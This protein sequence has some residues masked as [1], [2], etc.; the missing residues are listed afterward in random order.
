[1]FS[2][3]V[4][5]NRKEIEKY[6]HQ[7]RVSSIVLAITNKVDAE[8]TQILMNCLEHS[9]EV[10]P[11][12]VVYEQ[13]TGRVPVEHVGESWFVSMPVQHRTASAFY[14]FSKRVVDVFL[15]L[16]GI[17]LLTP[18]F[19][20]IALAIYIDSPGPTFYTQERV[21]KA[22]RRF[23][24]WKFRSMTNDAEKN[25][26]QWATKNDPRVTRVGKILRKTHLDEF[27]QFWNILK[28][29]MSAVGPR[30]ERPEWIE[31]L[32]KTIPFYRTRL[33][34]KPGM[35]GWGLVKQGYG[36]S[37]EDALVK[38]QYDL[39]Y[40]K[41]QS[42]FLDFVILLKTVLDTFSFGGR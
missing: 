20:L 18:I 14:R 28:G 32:E 38:L 42:I 4:L 41:H 8:L 27:P 12:A 13:L 39:Y 3:R 11:M 19:P 31:K 36:A 1:L 16:L 40:I 37:E 17:I 5:G 10:L 9:V 22:G 7:L 25:G 33:M 2:A 6:V 23:K 29:D 24:A 30:P 26:A 21:G 15:S 35:A 34:V